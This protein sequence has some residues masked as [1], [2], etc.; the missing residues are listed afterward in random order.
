MG[1]YSTHSNLF[2]VK[3]KVWKNGLASAI[4]VSAILE[5]NLDLNIAN[6]KL[7]RQMHLLVFANQINRSIITVQ[8]KVELIKKACKIAVEFGYFKMAWIVLDNPNHALQ[9][10]GHYGVPTELLD[11]IAST[12]NSKDVNQEIVISTMQIFICN[13]VQETYVNKEYKPFDPKYG[14][15]SCMIVPLIIDGKAI[16]AFNFLSEIPHYAEKEEIAILMELCEALSLAL[17]SIETVGQLQFANAKILKDEKRVNALLEKANDMLILTNSEGE[18]IHTSSSL[19]LF[20]GYEKKE[21]IKHNVFDFI[22]PEDLPVYLV[23]RN[24]MLLI[25]DFSFNHELRFLSKNGEWIWCDYNITNKLNLVD[26][27]AIVSSFR[28]ITEKRRNSLQ[29]EFGKNNLDAMMNTSSDMMWS[30]DASLNLL[31]ANKQF[32]VQML[33]DYNCAIPIGSSVLN[34]SFSSEYTTRYKK[35]YERALRGEIFTEIEK[36][37]F[38]KVGWAEISFFPILKGTELIGTACQLHDITAIKLAEEQLRNSEAFNLGV[39]NAL[40]AHIAVVGNAGVIIATNHAWK[41]YVQTTGDQ[42]LIK[43]KI[44]D[45]YYNV[46][47]AAFLNG[48]IHANI[49][50]NGMK[51]VMLDKRAF[52]YMEY[53]CHSITQKFWYGMHVLKLQNDIPMLVVTHQDISERMLAEEEVLGMELHLEEAQRLAKVGSW[54][55][56]IQYDKLTWSEELYNIFDTDKKAF[57]ATHGSFINLIENEDRASAI[58]INKIARTNGEPFIWEYQI[59]TNKGEKKTIQEHG[60]G[61]KDQLGKVVRLFGTAQDITSMKRTERIIKDYEESFE[62]EA[63][64]T[65]KVL[66]VWDIQA[67]SINRSKNVFDL[68][69]HAN[70][71]GKAQDDNWKKNIHKDDRDGLHNSRMMH[72]NN[73]DVKMWDYEYRFY[74]HNGE[75]IYLKDT[76]YIVR[77]LSG[78]ALRMV[79]ASA[80]LSEIKKSDLSLQKLLVVVKAQNE[81]L[82]NFAYIVSHNIRSHSANLSGLTNVFWQ[83]QGDEASKLV[84]YNMLKKSAD[85]LDETIENLN[86]VV[87]IHSESELKK[88]NLI[89]REEVDKICLSINLL[90][91]ENRGIIVNNIPVQTTLKVVPYYLESILLNLLTN[92]IKYRSLYRDLEININVRESEN[93]LILTVK[94]NGVGIDLKKFGH[95]IFGMYKTFNNMENSKGLGLFIV[96]NQIEAIGGKIEVE[97]QLN[98]GSAFSVYFNL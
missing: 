19:N 63:K 85:R 9:L 48:N 61:E 8:S 22:H 51:E 64:A 7:K 69:G 54:S 55:Y 76:G 78:K 14:V 43:S 30:V 96:K 12:Q 57:I 77:N 45:N 32:N 66:W 27:N 16:G 23:N 17:A 50:I 58:Q 39:I 29:L 47:E 44:G 5:K 97:S 40:S 13:T 11:T 46:C 37:F 72:L 59:I 95:K 42:S 87:A 20:F 2:E 81:R 67:N 31:T 10:A 6:D 52:F 71:G 74:K 73:P 28:D 91:R 36:R 88:D 15:Q 84:Y 34:S 41:N 92:S 25:P 35:Y 94:D 89:L 83:S 82:Q 80:N 26:V 3:D 68:Y 24:K 98:I 65:G 49:A 62:L 79:G 70:S 18:I 38:P 90:V 4:E 75:L 93:Y 53:P 21:V 56:D 1:K 86:Q 33:A 60:Y